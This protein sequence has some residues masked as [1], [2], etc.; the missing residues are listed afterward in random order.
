MFLVSVHDL[1][2]FKTPKKEGAMTNEKKKE[3]DGNCLAGGCNNDSSIQ[4][5]EKKKEESEKVDVLE[6]LNQYVIQKC[7]QALW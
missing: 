5:E 4:P 6:K 7:G 1:S 2:T 3:D